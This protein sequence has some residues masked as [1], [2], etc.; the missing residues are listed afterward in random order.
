MNR[1]QEEIIKRR[2]DAQLEEELRQEEADAQ[3]AK[4]GTTT[5]RFKSDETNPGNGPSNVRAD[6]EREALTAHLRRLRAAHLWCEPHTPLF[7]L[8]VH[9]GDTVYAPVTPQTRRIYSAAVFLAEQD[10]PLFDM[11][12]SLRDERFP[13]GCIPKKDSE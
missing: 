10:S 4:T 6:E 3:E 7:H 11:M 13:A 5:G 1:Q 2:K 8:L 9:L 12:R